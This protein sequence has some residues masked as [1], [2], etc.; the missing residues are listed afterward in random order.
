MSNSIDGANW[1]ILIEKSHH[2]VADAAVL[3]RTVIF[4]LKHVKNKLQ[5]PS[6]VSYNTKHPRKVVNWFISWLVG[7]RE[8]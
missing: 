7:G 3:K 2:L 8:I 4:S 1:N 6:K 5:T